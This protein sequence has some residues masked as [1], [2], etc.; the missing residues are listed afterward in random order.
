MILDFSTCQNGGQYGPRGFVGGGAFFQSRE[1]TLGIDDNGGDG[2]RATSATETANDRWPT[3]LTLSCKGRGGGGGGGRK[4]GGEGLTHL[5]ERR[6]FPEA[7]KDRDNRAPAARQREAD[8]IGQGFGNGTRLSPLSELVAGVVVGAVIGWG[9]DR[10]VSTS[11]LGFDR[12]LP[13][14][15]SPPAS[16]T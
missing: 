6:L 7:R 14:S 13:A 11:P 1:R 15:A 16:S 8:G 9:I 10:M 2:T 5:D 3:K 12:V 4:G